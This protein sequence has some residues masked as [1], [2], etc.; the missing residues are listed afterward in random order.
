MIG[1]G[2][3]HLSIEE[4]IQ[5]FNL[6]TPTVL[7]DVNISGWQSESHVFK[8]VIDEV[9]PNLII[10]IGSWVGASAIHM[11]SLTKAPIICVDTFLASN[12]DLWLE[13]KTMNLLENFDSIF[14]QFCINVTSLRLNKQVIPLPMTS[15]SAIELLNKFEI[16]ADMV[17]VDGGHRK[18]EVQADL[19]DWW[20]ITSKVLIGDDY[21]PRWN[22]VVEAADEFASKHELHLKTA[23]SKFILFR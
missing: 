9:N 12:F 21:S 23:D 5:R 7:G 3:K 11:A 4:F 10:E 17:Y 13:N 14:K 18:R 20:P 19:E 2:R 1:T 15:S 8:S 6:Q 16:K 22:G